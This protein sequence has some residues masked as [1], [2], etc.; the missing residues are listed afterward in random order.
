[1]PLSAVQGETYVILVAN[2]CATLIDTGDLRVTV[3][4]DDDVDWVVD[5][6]DNCL[7]VA[8]PDQGDDDCDEL[9]NVCDAIVN[10][11]CAGDCDENCSVT[12]DELVMVSGIVS[13]AGSLTDCVPADWDGDGDVMVNER[14]MAVNS[15]LEGCDG[16]G[17]GGATE[18]IVSIALFGTSGLRGAA[19]SF[20]VNLYN[21]VGQVAGVNLDFVYPAD[22]ITTPV[23][24]ED[25]R[26]T[27]HVLEVRQVAPDRLRLVLVNP[28]PESET[29]LAAPTTMTDGVLIVCDAQIRADAPFGRWA[30]GIERV[31]VSDVLGN[32]LGF[33]AATGSVEVI[34]PNTGPLISCGIAPSPRVSWLNLLLMALFPLG[35]ALRSRR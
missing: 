14:I 5:D 24:H 29:L 25:Q 15:A 34:D 10:P 23:C 19:V 9:G 3:G 26:L 12:S 16:N 11:P 32:A 27:E 8:N 35:L 1:M 18:P 33:Y 20:P 31:A 28:L 30:L 17:A 4:Y 6:E 13:S 22:A 21:G 2:S 7:T